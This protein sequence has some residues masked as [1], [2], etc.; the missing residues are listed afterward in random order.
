MM[1]EERES[2]NALTR[3]IDRIFDSIS[4][5][6]LGLVVFLASAALL[7][8]L[9]LSEQRGITAQA[10]GHADYMDHPARVA[11]FVTQV[12]ARPGDRVDVGTPLVELSPHFID[13]ELANLDAE[14]EKLLHERQLAQATL[15]ID[16]QRWLAPSVRL[17]PN[18]P[19]LESPTAALYASEIAMMQTRRKQLLSDRLAL[20]ITSRRAG[21]IVDIAVVGGA[22]A[23]STSVA[24]V[25][26]EY[27]E[28]IIAYVSSDTQATR[29]RKGTPVQI[30]RPIAGPGCR[31]DAVVLR[32]G[33]AVA[34]APGQ[35]VDFLRFPL[36]GMPIH[37][38]IPDGCK[39]GIGQTVTV[40]FH[41]TVI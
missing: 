10:V 29:I 7:L 41:E 16:E 6:P 17:R 32:R 1:G 2:W 9:S 37:I 33:A 24:S 35:L 21:L 13:R 34:E 18:Q 36:H 4:A 11:S 8:Q 27:A 28:E 5:R 23:A 30:A 22:V 38:S 26:A 39:L 14:I 25:T 15:I 3:T 31:G 20:T 19:S 12:F 40:E